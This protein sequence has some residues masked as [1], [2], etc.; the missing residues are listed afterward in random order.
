[1][2]TTTDAGTTWSKPQHLE[3]PNPDSAVNAL[4]LSNGCILLAFNKSPRGREN[5]DL[6]LSSDG[7]VTW[8]DVARIEEGK[9]TEFSYPY[10]IRDSHRRIHLVYTWMRKRIK[11]VVFNEAWINSKL[12]GVS[13]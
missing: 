6:A 13:Q 7:G 11:H 4:P 12:Q 5:L 1:M 2:A 8:Q 10:M 9:G 3:V